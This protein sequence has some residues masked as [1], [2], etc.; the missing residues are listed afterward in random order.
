MDRPA[1]RALFAVSRRGGHGLDALGVPPGKIEVCYL[2]IDPGAYRADAAARSAVRRE[3]GLDDGP[4]SCSAPRTCGP[5]RAWRCSRRSR[6]GSRPTGATP[7]WSRPATDRSRVRSPPPR[8]TAALPLERLRLLGPRADVPRLL[9]AAD[10][11]VFPSDGAEGLG[12][13]PLEALAAGVPVVATAV[14]DL[15]ELLAGA[16]VIVPPGDRDA[17][18]EGCRQLLDDP[19]RRAEL[20]RRGA[21]LV[22]ERLSVGSA[23]ETHAR[24]YFG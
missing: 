13:G 12:L 23:V 17:I 1:R 22:R 7:S 21:T 18:V 8:G 2:G 15:P 24:R 14:S 16:A 4:P 6:L 11:F 5:A 9:A 10:V 19:A 20:A 3:L